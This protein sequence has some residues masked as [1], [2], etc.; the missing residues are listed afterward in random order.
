MLHWLYQTFLEKAPPKPKKNLTNGELEDLI[1]QKMATEKRAVTISANG[2]MNKVVPFDGGS[3]NGNNLDESLEN[4][5]AFCEQNKDQPKAIVANTASV[6][7]SAGDGPNGDEETKDNSG[8]T[9]ITSVGTPQA[10]LAIDLSG[11][12]GDA[13]TDNEGTGRESATAGPY[14]VP[15]IVLPTQQVNKPASPQPGDSSLS[16]SRRNSNSSTVGASAK[17]TARGSDELATSPQVQVRTKPGSAL[18]SARSDAGVGD[19]S[20]KSGEIVR[21]PKQSPRT[22]AKFDSIRRATSGNKGVGLTTIEETTPEALA[23]MENS[24]RDADVAGDEFRSI[25]T[26]RGKM[27]RAARLAKAQASMEYATPYEEASLLA[28]RVYDDVR[29]ESN[30]IVSTMVKQVDTPRVKSRYEYRFHEEQNRRGRIDDETIVAAVT[31]A[32]QRSAIINKEIDLMIYD[33]DKEAH[34]MRHFLIDNLSGYS[35]GSGS[36]LFVL[37]KQYAR[38]DRR[39]HIHSS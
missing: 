32:R 12:G 23:A 20:T 17:N 38:Y 19:G 9:N 1:S 6:V 35:R 2:P 10:N 13:V 28:Q 36:S 3:D 8:S 22:G 33:H 5:A 31:Q 21:T 30:F 26:I 7:P 14:D 11:G 39:R 29:R 4:E 25:Q 34:L 16:L 37:R 27:L 18:N 15:T 24:R